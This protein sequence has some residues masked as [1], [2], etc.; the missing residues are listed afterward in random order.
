MNHIIK[1][2]SVGRGTCDCTKFIVLLE[3]TPESCA[4]WTRFYQDLY[5]L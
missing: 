3:A 1:A 4:T 2:K 5:T